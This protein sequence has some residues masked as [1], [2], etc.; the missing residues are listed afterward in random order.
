M[1]DQSSLF[2]TFCKKD[3]SDGVILIKGPIVKGVS[4]CI[5]NECVDNASDLLDSQN[6]QV[7][8]ATFTTEH[9]KLKPREI[10][11]ELDKHVVGQDFCKKVLAVAIHNHYNR[12]ETRSDSDSV[13]IEKS[14]ILIA[15]PSG[16]GK[17]HVARMIAKLLNV[18]FAVVDATSLTESGYVGDDV[19]T[20][21]QRLITAADGDIGKAQHGIVYIDEIDKISRKA[22]SPSVTRDVSGEGVQEALLK[23]VEGTIVSVPKT[24][25]R[26]HPNE[27][28]WLIDTTDILFIAGGAFAHIEKRKEL[29]SKS[30]IGF[31][32][33]DDTNS[34]SA[35]MDAPKAN[36]TSDDLV[37]FGGLIPEFIGRFH[38]VVTMHQ[39][40]REQLR[41]ILVNTESSLT[42]QYTK[43]ASKAGFELEF[44]ECALDA[45]VDRAI[46]KKTGARSLRSIM[47]ES[48]LDLMYEAPSLSSIDKYTV[49]AETVKNGF[50]FPDHM[51]AA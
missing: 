8:G 34:P 37:E 35:T 47:E 39:L 25:N 2:C 20:I 11:A 45:I 46:E 28:Q 12:I 16:C 29:E 4:V 36:F 1:A 26:K 42:A 18:P 3:H 30:S 5:C 24:G 33:Q 38:H 44:S 10:T 7:S 9:E 31:S 23:L 40:T 13:V 48:L 15:G 17:S 19:S 6:N 43:L 32:R 21:L 27:D 49:T 22:D 41:S 50:V 51:R 14:N